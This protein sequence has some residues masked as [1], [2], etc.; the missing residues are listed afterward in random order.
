MQQNDTGLPWE[1]EWWWPEDDRVF[2]LVGVIVFIVFVGG[3][4]LPH[5]HAGQLQGRGR[6]ADGGGRHAGDA[7]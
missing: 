7:V 2:V 3:R 6:R 1:D 4:R 5:G